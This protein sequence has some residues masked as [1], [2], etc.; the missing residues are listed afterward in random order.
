MSNKVFVAIIALLGLGFFGFVVNNRVSA[1]PEEI[2]G[3]KHEVQE[4]EHIQRG[5]AHL[6]YNSDLPSSGPHYSDQGA[7]TA[8]GVYIEE[9]PPEIF[10]HNLEHGGIVIAHQP[11]LP[12]E[13][14]D[15]LR[16]LF[17]LPY[18]N[19]D[20]EPIKAIVMPR[21]SNNAPIQLAGWGWTLDLN[22]YNEETIIKFYLQRVG[23]APEPHAGPSNPPINQVGPNEPNN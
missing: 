23:K 7:P 9:V 15:K 22:E 1:P 20:F 11:N 19:P 12:A 8:W 10:V 4:A 21:A 16:A 13:Q 2:L 3:T 5:Q 17:S 18:S 6:A 14:L